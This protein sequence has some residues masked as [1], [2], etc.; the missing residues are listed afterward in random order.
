MIEDHEI[1]GVPDFLEGSP[2]GSPDLE[3]A[4]LDVE[5]ARQTVAGEIQHN[6]GLGKGPT[7]TCAETTFTRCDRPNVK[8]MA[9][10]HPRHLEDMV[11]NNGPV[12]P[13]GVASRSMSTAS[14]SLGG[15]AR[16]VGGTWRTWNPACA[17]VTG[18]AAIAASSSTFVVASCDVGQ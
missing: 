17:D 8:V 15:G 10:G 2:V 6:G 1:S 14:R 16:L 9:S 13:L 4:V 12:E 3:R 5:D 18:P 7:V 11:S